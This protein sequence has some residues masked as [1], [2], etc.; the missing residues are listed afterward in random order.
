VG[1]SKLSLVSRREGGRATC[2]ALRWWYLAPI[3]EDWCTG[4]CRG[5]RCGRERRSQRGGSGRDGRGGRRRA[6]RACLPAGRLDVRTLGRA[7]WGW[8]DSQHRSLRIDGLLCGSRSGADRERCHPD[9]RLLGDGPRGLP[10]LGCRTVGGG[11]DSN[12]GLLRDRASG[13]WQCRIRSRGGGRIGRT[14]LRRRAGEQRSRVSALQRPPARAACSLARWVSRPAG[15]A[16]DHRE[17]LYLPS[18][19]WGVPI[20]PRHAGASREVQ[21]VC[22]VVRAS[23]M[24]RHGSAILSPRLRGGDE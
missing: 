5:W 18:D 15:R 4:G 1:N 16:G 12:D 19:G 11:G 23:D 7:I 14:S 17:G 24:G 9:H 13:G 22:P 10:W 8:R 6:R 3:G 20:G 2:S 21:G